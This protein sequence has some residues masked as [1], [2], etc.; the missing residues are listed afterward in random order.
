MATKNLFS[1]AKSAAPK[2]T[3]A[4]DEKVRITIEDATFFDKIQK[5]EVLQDQMKVAK[6]KADMISDELRDLGKDEWAKLYD[7]TGK[8]PGSVMLEQTV[9]EDVAQLMFVPTDKYITINEARAE[10]LR[11]VYG[12]EIVTEETTF[13]FDSAMIEKYGEIL[14][15]LIEESNEIDEKDKEKIITAKTTFTVAKGTIDNFPK[16]GNVNE[17]MEAVKP[18]VALKNVEIIKG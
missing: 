4:K 14:S 18:V 5:L 17:V 11:E 13:G 9:N 15:R 1:K 8:N 7:K 2:T 16:F 10:E 12:E 6:A 3:K